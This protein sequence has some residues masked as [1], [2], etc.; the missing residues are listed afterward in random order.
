MPKLTTARKAALDVAV[1]DAI[2][3]AVVAVL[4]EHGNSGLTMDRVA[5]TAGLAK[6]SLYNYFRNK[7]RLLHFVYERAYEPIQSQLDAIS[8]S[9]RAAAGK[10]EAI[11]RM[12]FEYVDTHRRLFDFLLN[13]AA[14][15]GSLKNEQDSLRAHAICEL[16]SI[17]EKGIET[18]EFRA[19]NPEHA[20]EL[21]LGA[22]RQMAERQL[23]SGRME[24]VDETVDMLLQVFL[25]GLSTGKQRRC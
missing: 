23:A 22:V 9:D 21:L 14:V 11:A 13:D 10:L 3:E 6:G 1:R 17:V 4:D 18:G 20:A 24:S 8:Q 25:N 2:Y 19:V 16:T 5:S 12:Y 7:Q 15:R